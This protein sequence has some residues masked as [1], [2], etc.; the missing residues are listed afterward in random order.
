MSVFQPPTSTPALTPTPSK[1]DLNDKLENTI[2]SESELWARLKINNYQIAVSHSSV[3]TEYSFVIRVENNEITDSKASC[4]DALLE[5]SSYCE[6]VISDISPESYTI[7]GL[8]DD[9]KKSR[10]YF[11][12]DDWGGQLISSW[13]ESVVITFDLQYHYPR[14]IQYDIPEGS[15]EE[16]TITILSFII[17]QK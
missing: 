9:L 12:A 1:E 6:E 7:Q 15:D 4:E 11:E 2:V 14:K 10:R 16:Y 3:W 17:L 13:S 8:F 5:D